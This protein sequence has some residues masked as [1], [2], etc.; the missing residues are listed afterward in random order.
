MTPAQLRHLLFCGPSVGK[1]DVCRI[2]DSV[3]RSNCSL[4][5]SPFLTPTVLPV[6]PSSY[7]SHAGVVVSLDIGD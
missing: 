2:L 3:A 6:W 1:R 7:A 4:G 5:L